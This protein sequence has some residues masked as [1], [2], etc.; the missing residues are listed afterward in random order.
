MKRPNHS[1]I[2]WA[3]DEWLYLELPAIHGLKAHSI[4]VPCTEVG[5]RAALHTLQSRS[6]FSRIGEPGDPT[7]HNVDQLI[8]EFKGEIKRPKAR[9]KLTPARV[10]AAKDILRRMGMI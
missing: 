3:T 4:R 8:K 9:P 7:Q 2:V 1:A 6:E 10:A 5:L